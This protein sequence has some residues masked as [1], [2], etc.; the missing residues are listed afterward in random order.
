MESIL[1]TEKAQIMLIQL[2]FERA[3]ERPVLHRQ[4]G[5]SGAS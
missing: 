3:G 5:E 1:A 2:V 4:E